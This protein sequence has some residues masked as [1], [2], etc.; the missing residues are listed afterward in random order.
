MARV[1]Q[2][3]RRRRPITLFIARVHRKWSW[4]KLEWSSFSRRRSSLNVHFHFGSWSFFFCCCFTLDASAFRRELAHSYTYSLWV[5]RKWLEEYNRWMWS[6]CCCY[7]CSCPRC[8]VLVFIVLP[9]HRGVVS[10]KW[11]R[12]HNTHRLIT[13][14]PIINN[15]I[16][17]QTLNRITREPIRW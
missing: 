2:R 5:C 1:A 8:A 3:R 4:I 14:E 13:L 7:Y 10:A 17:C 6:D 16:A 9:L 12:H 11:H 15:A